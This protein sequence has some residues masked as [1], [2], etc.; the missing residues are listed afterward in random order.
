MRYLYSLAKEKNVKIIL[1]GGPEIDSKSTVEKLVKEGIA[2]L[3]LLKKP[4]TF[5]VI[6][7][8]N[9]RQLWV[10]QY[11]RRGRALGVHYS[12]KPYEEAWNNFIDIFDGIK[13][14]G[15]YFEKGSNIGLK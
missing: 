10:E 11:H 4:T 14:T 2:E 8:S 15:K 7:C 12:T 3:Y 9:P 5:H 1:V 6:Y 13:E